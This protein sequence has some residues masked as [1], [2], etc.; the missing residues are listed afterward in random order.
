LASVDFQ[1]R[2]QFCKKVS[3]FDP[4]NWGTDE[5]YQLLDLITRDIK[6]YF[7][8]LKGLKLFN[9]QITPL[10]DLLNFMI[11]F[12]CEKNYYEVQSLKSFQDNLWK[13]EEPN[14]FDNI[15]YTKQWIQ[16]ASVLILTNALKNAKNHE[17]IVLLRHYD[18]ARIQ[19]SFTSDSKSS[20]YYS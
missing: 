2:E 9:L 18:F 19:G 20:H 16:N 17:L 8:F 13:Y 1:I 5:N 11:N 14:K 4:L 12:F 15:F 7:I 3:D 6:N 10:I